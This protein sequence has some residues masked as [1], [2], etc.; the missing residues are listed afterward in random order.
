MEMGNGG[1]AKPM[2]LK[3]KKGLELEFAETGK[4]TA[5]ALWL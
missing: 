1:N 3:E 5:L 2:E 4:E